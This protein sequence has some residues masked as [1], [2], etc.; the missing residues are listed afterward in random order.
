MTVK[1]Q[2][3]LETAR[4]LKPTERAELIEE[5]FN[6]FDSHG[7]SDVDK[8][9]AREVEDRIDAFEQGKIETVSSDEVFE[10]IE[11]E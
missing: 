7:L 10:D 1:T 9:W 11:K 6:T 8:L 5:L 4:K 3:L 2:K